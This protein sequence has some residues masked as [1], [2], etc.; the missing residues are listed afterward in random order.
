DNCFDAIGGIG[1]LV[2]GKT[3]TVKINLTGTDFT[4]FLDRPVGETFMTHEST[5]LALTSSLFAAGA[6]R[7]R[8]VQSTPS[9]ATLENTLSLADWD[10]NALRA[11]GDV[12]LENTRNLGSGKSYSRLKVPT[13]GY[14][15][16]SLDV[17]HSYEDTDV[18]V[19]LCK[20]KNHI[21]AGVTLSMK[22]LF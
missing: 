21:T 11:L 17:N 8:L 14:M 15:F 19:S 4:A 6:K 22:N 12:Q 20:M 9:R 10:V 18:M 3:V 1:S 13:G 7:V 5:M 16:S 2:K